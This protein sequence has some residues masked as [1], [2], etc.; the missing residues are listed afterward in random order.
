MQAASDEPATRPT[1]HPVAGR[2]TVYVLRHAESRW[3]VE[4]RLQGQTGHVPLSARGRRQ[5]A[6]L[7]ERLVGTGAVLVVSSDL[8][9][10]ADTARPVAARLGVPL[11]FDVALRE[12]A[13][14]V[15]EGRL[16][17]EVRALTGPAAWA[18]PDWRPPGGESLRD[19]HGRV[20][21]AVD[22]L[23][24]T[25]P[26]GPVV[27][28]THGDT[29]RVALAVLQGLGPGAETCRLPANAEVVEVAC[30]GAGAA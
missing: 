30:A 9:R 28:V 1:L 13:L 10:A 15:F 14:G 18:D 26:G 17:T 2:L 22:R 27:L 7:G 5:A 4:G 6:E 19:V 23:R 25:S 29:A 11:R 16:A 3:N 8:R 20:A 24:R 12:Q 21:A